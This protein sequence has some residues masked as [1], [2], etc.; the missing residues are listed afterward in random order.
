ML[1]EIVRDGD[2]AAECC[3]IMSNICTRGKSQA[4]YY[5]V[6]KSVPSA[7]NVINSEH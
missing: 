1:Q 5:S 4:D 6:N 3:W 7:E 2:I